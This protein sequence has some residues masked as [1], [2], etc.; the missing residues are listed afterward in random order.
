MSGEEPVDAAATAAAAAARPRPVRGRAE[1]SLVA[2]LKVGV[3]PLPGRRG[4]NV[5]L[6][7]EV[8][9]NFKIRPL[10]R[11]SQDRCWPDNQNKL[12]VDETQSG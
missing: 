4:A 10:T 3:L 8:L 9:E 2:D 11:R 1:E 12:E 7:D 6:L 5:R